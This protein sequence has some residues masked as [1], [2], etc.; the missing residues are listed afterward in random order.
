MTGFWRVLYGPHVLELDEERARGLAKDLAELGLEEG[1]VVVEIP[2]G[3]NDAPLTILLSQS[4][5]TA[6]LPPSTPGHTDPLI[7]AQS[8]IRPG[9]S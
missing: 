5:P 1:P 6:I 4:I 3:E 9:G 2:T 7:P 8:G